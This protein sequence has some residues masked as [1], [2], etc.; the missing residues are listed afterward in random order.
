MN[1]P[2]KQSAVLVVG[3]G[4]AGMQAA[5]DLADMGVKVY[6]LDRAPVIGG[7]VAQLERTFPEGQ[8]S[9]CEV[10]AM[11]DAV[12][13]HP[14]IELITN[15]DLQGIDGEQ[16][17]FDIA[18]KKRA[19][20][21]T[22]KCDGC[23]ACYQVCPVKPYNTYNEGLAL[24]C[25]IDHQNY[26]F[27]P[28]IYNIEK[29]TPACQETCP[30]HIDIRR[31]VGLIA[32]GKF[33]EALEVIRERNPLPSICGR[34]CHHPCEGMCNR[35][36]QDEPIAIEKLK[37]FAVDYEMNL[38]RQG[39]LP[40]PS[41]PKK[42][43]KEKVAIVGAGPAGLTCGH[44]LAKLGYE[45]TIFEKESV[46]GGMLYLC[47]PEYRL[48]R[49]VIEYDVDSIRDL[50]VDI[51]LGTPIGKDLT[52]DDL[53]KQGYKAI[54]MGI[55]AHKGLKLRVPGED[56]F[57][58]FID[59]IEFLKRVNLGDKSKPG[60]RVIVIGGGNSAIDSAR[61]ALR[62]GCEEVYILYR[63][64]RKE[65]P[66]N[67]WEIE[68]AEHEGVQIHYLAA[69]VKILGKNGRV[70]GMECTKMELGKLDASGRR[71]PIPIKGSEFTIEA[72]V[73]IPAI[74]QQPD[75][76]FLS[77]G[78]GLEISRWD[79]FVIDE[80]TMQTNLPDVFAG[81][82]AVTGPATVI[83]AIAAGHRAAAG[84]DHYLRAR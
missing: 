54:F 21:V 63:R 70:A 7:A 80:R 52:L 56:E 69:P 10:G 17:S 50:G 83:E 6:L 30:V 1:P 76:S 79:S 37:R 34:V 68:E 49:D 57:E 59:C 40:K 74:S 81:G 11:V 41:P 71:R 20:R 84:I 9:S 39:L 65:M 28:L 27:L 67:E 48:P 24:R 62:L 47:I 19:F 53:R 23:G 38:R 13:H 29:E 78:H 18:V 31:Y 82:D 58:G 51:R 36:Q 44:D 42:P 14:N 73:I 33:L 43:T 2:H 60:K 4:V 25:A 72:D 12:S 5:L 35:G 32:E 16:G 15:A 77:E 55:G 75:I 8:S 22:E 26:S 66:A 64:S 61:V 46:P 45:V 3:A